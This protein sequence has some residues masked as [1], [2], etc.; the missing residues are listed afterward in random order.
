ML[1]PRFQ[2]T[3][4]EAIVQAMFCIEKIGKI[5]QAEALLKH[6]LAR[7][8]RTEQVPREVLFDSML[9]M[10]KHTNRQEDAKVWFET[11]LEVSC[12]IVFHMRL[13]IFV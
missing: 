9:R 6:F 7:E 4:N 12:A 5:P 8:N 3:D 13:T 11:S 2:W 10:Y 1:K